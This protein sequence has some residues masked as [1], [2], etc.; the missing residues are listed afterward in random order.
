MTGRFSQFLPAA[1]QDEQQQPAAVPIAPA[2]EER[3][4]FSTRVKPSQKAML[5]SYIMEL[6]KAGWPVSQEGVL[7]ELL[8]AL[9]TDESFRATITARLTKQG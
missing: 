2:R 6:K 8:R 9:E 4:P 1:A 3:R 5:D 7:E